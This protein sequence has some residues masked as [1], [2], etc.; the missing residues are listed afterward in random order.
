MRAPISIKIGTE[1]VYMYPKTG[2][3]SRTHRN[4]PSG[5]WRNQKARDSKISKIISK[6]VISY[7]FRIKFGVMKR[8]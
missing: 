7:G 8:F 3:K 5:V 4:T 2:K 1:L 6:N